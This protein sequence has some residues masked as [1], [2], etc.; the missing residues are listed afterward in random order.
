[1]SEVE[2]EK[3]KGSG[4]W[5]TPPEEKKGVQG[6]IG[7]HHHHRLLNTSVLHLPI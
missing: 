1:M 4:G 6:N 2:D 3:A 5:A 7:I